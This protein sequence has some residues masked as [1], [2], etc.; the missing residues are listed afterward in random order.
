MQ[1]AFYSLSPRYDARLQFL[2]LQI[3]MLKSRLRSDRVVPTPEEKA[4]LLRLGGELNHDISDIIAIVK[5]ETYRKWRAQSLEGKVAKRS[6]PAGLA[7]EVKELICRLAKE[8]V[9]WGYRRI[10]GELKK[11]GHTVA[12]SSVKRVI[13]AGTPNEARLAGQSSSLQKMVELENRGS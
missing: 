2:L 11:L 1:F 12:T 3:R 8:N 4:E 7:T 10:V 6:G 9:L 5:P 13:Q